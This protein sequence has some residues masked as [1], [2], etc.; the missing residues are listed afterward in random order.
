MSIPLMS[1]FQVDADRHPTCQPGKIVYSAQMDYDKLMWLY[2]CQCNCAVDKEAVVARN[3][4]DVYDN[5]VMS[6]AP[7]ACCCG[8]IACDKI[9]GF[10]FDRDMPEPI[11]GGCC[12]P[13]PWCC[14]HHCNFCGE[15]L[16]FKRCCGCPSFVGHWAYLGPCCLCP[17]DVIAGLKEN[18]AAKLAAKIKDAQAAF[19]ANP[20]NR[21]TANGFAQALSMMPRG[22]ASI[23]TMAYGGAGGP[24]VGGMV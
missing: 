1:G 11:A 15:T 10:Y 2:R 7:G 21:V 8:L 9:G 14:P 3:F 18:E 6:N 4:V 19:R 12:S 5:M 24:G 23:V 22:G 17:T 16:A 13:F 20:V